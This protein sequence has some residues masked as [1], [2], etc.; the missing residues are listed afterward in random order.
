MSKN[1]KNIHYR[2]TENTGGFIY[3]LFT[4][5]V[6]VVHCPAHPYHMAGVCK[7]LVEKVFLTL[8][9]LV[10][11]GTTDGNAFKENPLGKKENDKRDGQ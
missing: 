1:Q 4:L 7:H 6:S 5:C 3:F 11:P 10:N 2:S 8:C 9:L